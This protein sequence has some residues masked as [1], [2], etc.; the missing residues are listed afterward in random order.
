LQ[1][2]TNDYLP[3]TE[4]ELFGPDCMRF[5]FCVLLFLLTFFGNHNPHQ[6]CA[7]R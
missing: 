6:L 1:E 2:E 7:D 4:L 5:G 3:V